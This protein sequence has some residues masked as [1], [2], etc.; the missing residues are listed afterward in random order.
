M[1]YRRLFSHR[2]RSIRVRDVE[3]VYLR[4]FSIVPCA[5]FFFCHW[6]AFASRDVAGVFSCAVEKV[7]Y[8]R[9]RYFTFIFGGEVASY[10]SSSAILPC[11]VVPDL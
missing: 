7:F 8:M 2:V 10:C 5:V 6:V 3:G 4:A 11:R 1:E 9:G